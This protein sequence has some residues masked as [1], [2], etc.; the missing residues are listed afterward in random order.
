MTLLIVSIW[1]LFLLFLYD[2]NNFYSDFLNTQSNLLLY[3][4]LLQCLILTP[5]SGIY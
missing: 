4:F 2:E 3:V 1:R 5:S